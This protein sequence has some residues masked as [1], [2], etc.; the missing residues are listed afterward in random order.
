MYQNPQQN[1][2]NR[3]I[4][5]PFKDRLWTNQ[6]RE[7][8]R[9]NITCY[10][11]NQKGHIQRV[12]PLN[13]SN[14]RNLANQ[15]DNPCSISRE[16]SIENLDNS[17]Y[18]SKN[19]SSYAD[20]VK[21]GKLMVMQQSYSKDILNDSRY[22]N[23]N[24]MS[25]QYL[26]TIQRRHIQRNN[27]SMTVITKRNAELARNKPITHGQ[28]NGE[29]CKVFLDT[30]SD[31]NVIDERYLINN[32]KVSCDKIKRSKKIVKCANGSKLFTKGI[33][34]LPV[35]IGIENKILKFIVVSAL[36]PNIIV[37]IRGM[38]TLNLELNISEGCVMSRGIR[39]PF[40][41]KIFE[42]SVSRYSKNSE[43]SH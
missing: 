30:G 25:K 33:V 23:G 6:T 34:E 31:T 9:N 32:L 11:C 18:I 15:D 28:V 24:V 40:I 35:Q 5:L 42:E 38:K 29:K 21:N 26:K 19:S 27:A 16:S 14:I 13:R 20:K 12:C 7:N 1:D 41:S 37:G 3:R 17:S 39:I 36:F 43:E 2:H 10:K 22:I 4:K 8:N